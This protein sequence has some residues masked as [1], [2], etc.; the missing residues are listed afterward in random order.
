MP[1]TSQFLNTRNLTILGSEVYELP[2][3]SILLHVFFS[4]T[5]LSLNTSMFLRILSAIEFRH[6]L[7]FI[8]INTYA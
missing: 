4:L 2:S 8:N 6:K 5:S 7:R 3:P 1:I